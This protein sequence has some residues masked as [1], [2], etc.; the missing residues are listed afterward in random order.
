MGFFIEIPLTEQE[1]KEVEVYHETCFEYNE[2][3]GESIPVGTR[4]VKIVRLGDIGFLVHGNRAFAHCCYGGD[5]Y[6]DILEVIGPRLHYVDG[7]PVRVE[8]R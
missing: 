7:R 1:L 2:S 6:K 8:V 4:V 3:C 5:L